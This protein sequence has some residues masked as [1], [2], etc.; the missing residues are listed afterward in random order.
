M[1]KH[2][3]NNLVAVVTE[4]VMDGDTLLERRL[5]AYLTKQFILDHDI[6]SDECLAEARKIIEMVEEFQESERPK[7]IHAWRG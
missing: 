4:D 7:G 2:R 1:K 6:P 5:N 3:E